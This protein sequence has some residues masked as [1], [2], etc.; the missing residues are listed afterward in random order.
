MASMMRFGW[1]VLSDAVLQDAYDTWTWQRARNKIPA[2]ALVVGPPLTAPLE[3]AMQHLRTSGEHLAR[4]ALQY[5]FLGTTQNLEWLDRFFTGS[6]LPA[7]SSA[8]GLAVAQMSQVLRICRVQTRLD[9][10]LGCMPPS[11]VA[12]MLWT[13]LML[14]DPR[15]ARTSRSVPGTSTSSGSASR[16]RRA[17]HE[18]FWRRLPRA[19]AHEATGTWG[20]GTGCGERRNERHGEAARPAP[21]PLPGHHPGGECRFLTALAARQR[22][23]RHLLHGLP[24]RVLVLTRGPEHSTRGQFICASTWRRIWERIDE[25]GAHI[26][27]VEWVKGHATMQHVRAGTISL[28]HLQA[29]ELADEQ[30]KKGSAL[31]PSVAQV[32]GPLSWDGWPSSWVGFVHT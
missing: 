6:Q 12:G 31:H 29:N 24:E 26:I 16:E 14:A 22:D 15:A 19:R 1:Q 30:A 8:W 28:W 32:Q 4:G 18:R 10:W 13:R 3:L 17:R 11:G 21:R 27:Q 7:L 5:V 20:L 23:G 25:I 9:K 2:L